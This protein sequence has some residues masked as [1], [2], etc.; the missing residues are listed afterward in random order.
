MGDIDSVRAILR[1]LA[2]VRDGSFYSLYVDLTYRKAHP[3]P[4]IGFRIYQV[5]N[6]HEAVLGVGVSVTRPDG[7]IVS[8]SLS[9]ET[10]ARSLD[11]SGTV[12]LTDDNGSREVFVRS[13]ETADLQQVA[14]LI[15][16]VA[17]EVCAQKHWF[18]TKEEREKLIEGSA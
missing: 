5:A 8:W 2:E 12:E 16:N 17:D 6:S 9:I 10:S 3:L 1:A 11:I 4:Q 14:N 15:H 7:T 18:E 13:A